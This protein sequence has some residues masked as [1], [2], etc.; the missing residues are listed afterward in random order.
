MFFNF[1]ENMGSISSLCQLINNVSMS[2]FFLK[3]IPKT[4]APAVTLQGLLEYIRLEH[5]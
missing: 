2:S 1:K 4:F 3:G 5:I